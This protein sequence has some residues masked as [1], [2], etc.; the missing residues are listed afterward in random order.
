MNP[1][2]FV[3]YTDGDEATD[4][5]DLSA[6]AQK[7]LA[8]TISQI[9]SLLNGEQIL[10]VRDR[11]PGS[12]ECSVRLI[13]AIGWVR[14][15][16]LDVTVECDQEST[17]LAEA[18]PTLESVCN[19]LE[20]DKCEVKAVLVIASSRLLIGGLCATYAMSLGDRRSEAFAEVPLW[21]CIAYR[22]QDKTYH[23]LGGERA[24][25]I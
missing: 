12:L 5:E 6:A 14:L 25:Q 11:T 24:V 7:Q 8:R 17:S 22:P 21:H 19:Q 1:L 2:L 16:S 18:R 10:I 20:L 3:L 23:V 9:L 4:N 13:N 15:I